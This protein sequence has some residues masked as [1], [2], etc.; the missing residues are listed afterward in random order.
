MSA[1]LSYIIPFITFL[2][3]ACLT[4]F[5]KRYDRR[6][7]SIAFYAKDLS[8]CAN[9]WYNQLYEI[10]SAFRHGESAEEIAKRVEFY[11]R[12]RL[13]LPKFLR[14]L[15]ALKKHGEAKQIVLEAGEMLKI[16]AEPRKLTNRSSYACHTIFSFMGTDERT[17]PVLLPDFASPGASPLKFPI[18]ENAKPL[19]SVV[20]LLDSHVQT[21]NIEA[22]KIL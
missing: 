17:Q 8:D 7:A 13:V 1:Y 22:G 12:N 16:L 2:L 11:S 14:A 4:L 6:N 5:L 20:T 18:A 10:E 21:I 19:N 9:E 15:E 3:G